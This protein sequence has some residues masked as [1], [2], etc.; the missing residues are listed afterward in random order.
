[1]KMRVETK[2]HQQNMDLEGA[3]YDYSTAKT[4]TEI[5]TSSFCM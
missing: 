1:M 2:A 5:I 4:H 3:H